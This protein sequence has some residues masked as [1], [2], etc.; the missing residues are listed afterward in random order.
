MAQVSARKETM[1]EEGAFRG[2]DS[3]P[4]QTPVEVQNGHP[5][6]SASPPVGAAAWDHPDL[7]GPGESA[8]A[9]VA[10]DLCNACLHREAGRRSFAFHP[11]EPRRMEVASRVSPIC[12][13]CSH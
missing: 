7:S 8:P 13:P 11:I 12:L 1:L 6:P 5:K 4:T 2:L 9:A 10:K 3:G